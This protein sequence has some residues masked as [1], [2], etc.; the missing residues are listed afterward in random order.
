M[1]SSKNT[2]IH[3]N[4]SHSG[5][6]V[7]VGISSKPIGVDIQKVDKI[8]LSIARSCFSKNENEYI[9]S[10]PSNERD[11]AFL[12]YGHLKRHL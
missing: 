9:L 4:I 6:W 3:F 8:D 11:D 1:H 12:S 5:D 7:A 10:L 2:R